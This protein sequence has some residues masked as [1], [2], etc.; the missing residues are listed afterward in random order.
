MGLGGEALDRVDAQRAYRT[1]IGWAEGGQVDP[2]CFKRADSLLGQ[3]SDH[4]QRLN[5]RALRHRWVVG[6][7]ER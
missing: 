6:G 7:A 4:L 5:R 2:L 1:G 3:P